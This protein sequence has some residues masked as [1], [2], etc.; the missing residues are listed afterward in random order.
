MLHLH[1]DTVREE[2][3]GKIYEKKVLHFDKTITKDDIRQTIF[4][5]GHTVSMN[6]DSFIVTKPQ[7]SSSGACIR[8]W[9]PLTGETSVF[10]SPIKNGPIYGQAIFNKQ[11]AIVVAKVSYFN[12]NKYGLQIWDS[13]TT[14]YQKIIWLEKTI[15]AFDITPDGTRVVTLSYDDNGFAYFDI[16]G[17]K[18]G[19]C[20]NTVKT[21]SAQYDDSMVFALSGDSQKIIT[22]G[23]DEL[24]QVWDLATTKCQRIFRGHEDTIISLGSSYDSSRV[25]SVDKSGRMI[26]WDTLTGERLRVISAYNAMSIKFNFDGTHVVFGQPHDYCSSDVYVVDI[27][28]TKDGEFEFGYHLSGLGDKITAVDFCYGGNFWNRQ[29]QYLHCGFLRDTF[30]VVIAA[31]TR[32]PDLAFLPTEIWESIF[33]FIPIKSSIITACVDGTSTIKNL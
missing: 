2:Y 12:D 26:I 9:N 24:V 14:I 22:G 11:K 31:S 5:V 18:Y 10:V 3:E 21:T 27:A 25:A 32:N 16:L 20:L 29:I 7:Y 17:I 23:E 19:Q 4:S 13:N 8:I 15:H 30:S 28:N 33:E 6:D 1:F